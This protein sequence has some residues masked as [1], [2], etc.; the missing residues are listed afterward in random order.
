M[1]IYTKKGDEGMT[2]LLRGQRVKKNDPVIQASGTIDELN[3]FIGLVGNGVPSSQKEVIEKIQS[4]LFALGAELSSIENP[5]NDI[6][7]LRE[8]DIG[9][10]E[11]TIDEIDG[12]LPALKHFIL[13]AGSLPVVYCH[14]ARTVCRRA[15]RNLVTLLESHAIEPRILAFIN[16][17]SDYMFVLARYCSYHN[18]EEEM[19]WNAFE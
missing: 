7:K 12:E 15:E 4:R 8:E 9:W 2:S 5:T 17:L 19:K 16:R 11:K 6:P 14:L 10:L 13:P 18:G 3:A 1:K